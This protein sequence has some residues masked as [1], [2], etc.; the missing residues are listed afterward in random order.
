MKMDYFYD[1][2]HSLVQRND[3]LI[4]DLDG[5]VYLGTEP[6][7]SAIAA[8]QSA[9]GDGMKVSYLTNNA[10]RTPADVAGLLTG[11]NLVVTE[12]DVVTSALVATEILVEKL[13]S[14]AKV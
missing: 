4:C 6:I 3:L 1:S 2:L 5:V 11:M 13:D 12:D 8:L 14:G 10:S 7:S 9:S